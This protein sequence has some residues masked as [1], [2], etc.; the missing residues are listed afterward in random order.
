M[1]RQVVTQGLR[2]D[3][4]A[5]LE[6]RF[7][8]LNLTVSSRLSNVP[9]ILIPPSTS[10]GAGITV[11]N[12]KNLESENV[13][14]SRLLTV[15]GSSVL[16]GN[17]TLGD[18][19][20]DTITFNSNSLSIPN[21]L[22]F[23]DG[24]V[25]FSSNLTNSASSFLT[26]ASVS[27]AF[28]VGNNKFYVSGSNNF[29]GLNTNIPSTI[30]EVQGTASASYLN[31][32]GTSTTGH[33]NYIT[34]SDDVMISGDLE[35]RGT[36]SFGGVASVSGNFFTY[37]TNTFSGTGSS[38]FAGSLSVA[39]GFLA[40][41]N[42]A[43]VVNGSATANTLN[44]VGGNVG[45]GTTAPLAPLHVL[46]QCVTGD[47]RLRRRRRKNKKRSNL[48]SEK[49]FDLGDG[50]EDGYFYDEVVIKDIQP[51]D[52][53]L[54]LNEQTG[55]LEYQKVKGL[56]DMGV[57]P[58]FKLTT[59][60]GKTIRTTGNHPYLVRIPEDSPRGGR[61]FDWRNQKA[62]FGAALGDFTGIVDSGLSTFYQYSSTENK[63]KS[64]VDISEFSEAVE[65]AGVEP[66]RPWLTSRVFYPSIPTA[67]QS[68]QEDI[69][70]AKVKP[71]EGRWTKVISLREGQQIAV[72]D[73]KQAVWD[74]ITKIE[75]LPSEQVYDIEVENTHNFIGNDIV[76]H[77]TYLASG[78]GNV[79]IRTT[80]PST[81]FEVQ[82]TASASYLLTTDSAPQPPATPTT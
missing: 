25:T 73:G 6:Q 2:I 66:A 81:L 78:T 69:G 3:S 39:K 36:A 80:S 4:L 71:S 79:G 51:G 77:N 58:I 23:S 43:F 11:L 56:M 22:T 7:N 68:Y 55:K 10:T 31:R 29:I 41:A 35:T 50:N 42:N 82:G 13:T 15:Q 75:T 37:G 26:N 32:F 57:K 38:S 52:E 34:S 63:V 1:G 46:G 19:S 61:K 9:T 64:I 45:V 14:I 65:M 62:A 5:S 17:T 21:N 76:A 44:V 33:S 67:P 49:R 74:T 70:Q 24:N 48:K 47:T 60:S 28:E 12:P 40:G 8:D 54:S 27:S 18:A 20:T 72:A 59:A 30:L 53:V 16:E